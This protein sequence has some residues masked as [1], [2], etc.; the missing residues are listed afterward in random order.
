VCVLLVEDEP[1]ILMATAFF[2][3][4]ASLK[5]MTANDGLHAVDLI[6]QH[7][8]YFTALVTD[9]HMPFATGAHVV[10]HMRRKYPDIPMVITTAL[11]HVVTEDWRLQHAVDMVGKPYNPETLVGLNGYAVGQRIAPS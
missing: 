8:G 11:T 3:E 5:V 6:D 9:F 1:V 4:E 10:M 2:L 7:P